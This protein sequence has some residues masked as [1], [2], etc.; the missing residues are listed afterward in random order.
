MRISDIKRFQAPEIA[1]VANS[2]NTAL[3]KRPKIKDEFARAGSLVFSRSLCDRILSQRDQTIDI[4][5]NEVNTARWWSKNLERM[6]R[7]NPVGI[8]DGK[9]MASP[10]LLNVLKEIA[11]DKAYLRVNLCDHIIE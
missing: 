2:K 1:A 3:G 4:S 10:E 6:V 5:D 7:A 8:P 11:S 9:K